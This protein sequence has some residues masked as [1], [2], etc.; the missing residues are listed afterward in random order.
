M[1]MQAGRSEGYGLVD[2]LLILAMTA[3]GY[4]LVF[5]GIAQNWH[6]RPWPGRGEM[7]A[8]ESRR[9]LP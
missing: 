1:G 7:P 8:A 2:V 9:D 5:A 6:L 4:W 3:V